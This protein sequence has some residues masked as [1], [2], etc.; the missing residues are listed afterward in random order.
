MR[1]SFAS[2]RLH[3]CGSPSG[4]GFERRQDP[5]WSQRKLPE[6]DARCI[7]ERVPDGGNHGR[8]HFFSGAARFLVQLLHDDRRHA[9]VFRK[10]KR[11]VAVPVQA[12]DVRLIEVHFFL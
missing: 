5:G 12:R 6:S 7:E 2:G 3:S 11:L 8:Q 9:G 4:A 10:P 1:I